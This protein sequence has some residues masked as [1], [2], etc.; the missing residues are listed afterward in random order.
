MPR[1]NTKKVKRQTSRTNVATEGSL[2][3]RTRNEELHDMVTIK[4]ATALEIFHRFPDLPPEIRTE[5]YHHI[6]DNHFAEVK[7]KRNPYHPSFPPN[8]IPYVSCKHALVDRNREIRGLEDGKLPAI[9]IALRIH[10]RFYKEFVGL[11]IA[12]SEL[13]LIPALKKEYFSNH[14]HYYSYDWSKLRMFEVDMKHLEH[15][16]F[17]IW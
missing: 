12:R 15:I 3:K 6:L 10:E 5:L 2:L 13:W 4:S 14:G 1:K 16:S 11:R 8:A 7:R 9:E 17:S